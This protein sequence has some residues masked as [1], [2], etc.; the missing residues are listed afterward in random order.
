MVTRLGLGHGGASHQQY[1]RS[2]L[3]V[4]RLSLPEKKLTEIYAFPPFLKEKYNL[5]TVA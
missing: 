2:R 4:G 1:G 3:C 5:Y